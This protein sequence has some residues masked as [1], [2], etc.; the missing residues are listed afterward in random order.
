MCIAGL[1]GQSYDIQV[2]GNE[3]GMNFGSI[4]RGT[5]DANGTI[6]LIARQGII[7]YNGVKFKIYAPNYLD[8]TIINSTEIRDITCDEKNNLFASTKDHLYKY[9]PI[10]DNFVLCPLVKAYPEKNTFQSLTGL[11]IEGDTVYIASFI[12]LFL[13]NMKTG[14]SSFHTLEEEETFR[15]HQ[16]TSITNWNIFPHLFNKDW[17]YVTGNGKL[18]IVNKHSAK[19]EKVIQLKS[20]N[21][22]VTGVYSIKKIYQPNKDEIWLSSWGGGLVKYNIPKDTVEVNFIYS[23]ATLWGK[24]YYALRSLSVLDENHLLL[25]NEWDYP[26]IYDIRTGEID[27]I[28]L[29]STDISNFFSYK[30]KAGPIWVGGNLHLFR[31]TPKNYTIYHPLGKN[32]MGISSYF[33]NNKIYTHGQRTD[34]IDVKSIKNRNE[35]IQEDTI[36]NVLNIFIDAKSDN[37]YLLNTD[38]TFRKIENGDIRR[39]EYTFDEFH[40][41]S[42]LEGKIYTRYRTSF[43]KYDYETG[44]LEV[45]LK[46]EDYITENVDMTHSHMK[47]SEDNICYFIHDHYIFR[48]NFK[49]NT[50]KKTDL[51][52]TLNSIS[53]A[54]EKDGIL[55]ISN[56]SNGLL[57][58]DL[59][60]GDLIPINM[61]D[62]IWSIYQIK[63]EGDSLI[64]FSQFNGIGAYNIHKNCVQY[65][66]SSKERVSL[67][68]K[69]NLYQN[70]AYALT[71][72]GVLLMDRDHKLANVSNLSCT[73]FNVGENEYD[74]SS[75]KN[76]IL[77]HY[78]NDASMTW[79]YNYFGNKEFL[80]VFTQLEGYQTDWQ[81]EYLQFSRQYLNLAPGNY[82]FRVKTRVLCDEE[83]SEAFTF[84]IRPPWYQTLWFRLAA[85][86]CIGVVFYAISR[87][88]IQSITRKSV[89]DKKLAQLELKALKAQLNPHFVFNSLNAIKGLIQNNNNE[90]AVEY[91]VTFSSLVRDVL[92]FSEMKEISLR[93]ELE[94][95]EEYL[96]IESL[97]FDRGFLYDFIIEP[98]IDTDKIFLPPM[99]LQ[100][101]L[102]NSIWHGLLPKAKNETKE[103]T[104]RIYKSGSD[105]KISIRDNGVG[106]KYT[107]ELRL[108]DRALNHISRG[109]NLIVQ[110]LRLNT[111]TLGRHIEMDTIDHRQDTTGFTRG[112]EVIIT[113]KNDIQDEG[114]TRR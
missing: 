6:W 27:K 36:K 103:L 37:I 58:M 75:S 112:T 19:L 32:N 48:I 10:I 59:K 20:E 68:A 51:P 14:E 76:I 109:N 2:Y 44:N 12:G 50:I 65:Y 21:P 3:E 82:T 91:L 85:L 110:R 89:L 9:D 8:S 114:N 54:E 88:K 49:D 25:D 70:Y 60:T 34:Y 90:E 66:T 77:K 11:Y 26:A 81:P 57:K 62:K 43:R 73:G 83:F 105:I 104:I 5:E 71:I 30:S 101:Y 16:H 40:A 61:G 72:D 1:R 35:L 102:E 29:P 52:S 113:L 107:E 31:I 47:C 64:W 78:E 53:D 95:S 80:E 106:R 33:Q 23:P 100:P 92:D 56:R 4:V 46:M 39:G 63:V 41:I 38:R 99:L 97:R 18:R 98:G 15:N 84:T 87:Y 28:I 108:K 24:P 111:I 17:L 42:F 55:W 93:E 22:Y 96:R 13:Y 69:V 67:N 45:E 79:D 7:R 86:M 94:F 74:F